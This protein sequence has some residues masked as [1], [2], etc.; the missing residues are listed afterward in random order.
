MAETVNPKSD[1]SYYVPPDYLA[2]GIL[3]EEGPEN[4]CN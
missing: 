4:Y 3:K 1:E 2:N